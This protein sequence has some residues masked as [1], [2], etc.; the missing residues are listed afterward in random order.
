M[1]HSFAKS[2][3]EKQVDFTRFITLHAAVMVSSQNRLRMLCLESISGGTLVSHDGVRHVRE[4]SCCPIQDDFAQV[5]TRAPFV[6]PWTARHA[7]L[8]AIERLK[9]EE[10]EAKPLGFRLT[11]LTRPAMLATRLHL[12]SDFEDGPLEIVTRGSLRSFRTIPFFAFIE[13]HS[14]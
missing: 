12:S 7:L 2:S 10:R 6:S 9:D 14:S 11:T 4:T 1:E 8:D 13:L 5:D 3:H